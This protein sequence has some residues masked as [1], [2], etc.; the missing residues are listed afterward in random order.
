MIK[1]SRTKLFGAGDA[2]GDPW[3]GVQ[4]ALAKKEC[5]GMMGTVGKFGLT[6]R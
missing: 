3:F 6:A 5:F 1:K 4:I 2:G